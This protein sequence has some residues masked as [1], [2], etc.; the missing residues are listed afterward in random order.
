MIN[1]LS[2]PVLRRI[3]AFTTDPKGGNPAGVWLGARLPDPATMLRIAA[4]IGF[5]ET[6]FLSPNSEKQLEVRYYSPEAEVSFCGHATIA[7]GVL[8]GELMGEGLYSFSTKVG[9]VPVRVERRGSLLQ[10]SLTSVATQHRLAET[11][12]LERALVALGWSSEDLAEDFPSAVAYAGAWHLILAVRSKVTLDRLSYDFDAL[13][14][15]MVQFELTTLQLVWQEGESLFHSRNP[16]PVGGVVEDPATGAAAAALGGY[17]RDSGRVVTPHTFTI[18]QGEV[19]G[20]PSLIEV[21]V[22]ISGGI[23]V[24]GTGVPMEPTASLDSGREFGDQV[25]SEV[26]LLSNADRRGRRYVEGVRERRVFPSAECLSNLSVF[27]EELLEFGCP[28]EDTLELL[29]S[30][31][32]PATVVSNGPHYYGFVIGATLPVAV[33]AERLALAWDQCASS[34][35]NSPIADK[36]EK[37]AARW[38]LELLDLPRESAVSFGTSASACGLACLTAARRTLLL[39][40][41]WNFDAF[42]LI[43]APEI[44]VVVPASVH[45]TVRKALRLMGFGLSRLIEAPVDDR[46]RIDPL[47]LPPL[48]ERTILCLQAGEVN[49]GEFDDFEV[50]IGAA[51]VVGAWVHVDG[52]FGLW[53]RA[54]PSLR[55]LTQGIE[56]ADSWTTDGHKWLNTPYDGAMGICRDS[57]ALAGAMNSDAAYATASADSQKNLGI[58]FSRRARGIPIW[59]ALR[60]LGRSGVAEMVERHCRQA[61]R[62]AEGLSTVGVTLLNRVV[63]NQVLGRLDTDEQTAALQAAAATDGRIWF[64]PTVWEGRAAFRMSV[65]SWRTTDEDIDYAISLMKSYLESLGVSP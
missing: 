56:G 65:S 35:V 24:V 62:L 5:S 41:G 32:S 25:A 44:K 16:F 27:D 54:S 9:V 34:F 31:G 30:S 55:S 10:A 29:D 14:D 37:T 26:D 21:S 8:L 47:R 60:T 1:D 45:V 28:A 46:G 22:P 48:D 3:V 17:L 43:G 20:R 42:G 13:R 39:R 4:E 36:L 50:L 40:Q 6:A 58:E 52:A 38:V 18:R 53:A 2:T 63:L 59:A 49:A 11:E 7:S 19:M 57:A 64:G 61:R 23:T 51:K 12:L 15:L 33:A